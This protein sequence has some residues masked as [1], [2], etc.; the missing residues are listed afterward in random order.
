MA[1]NGRLNEILKLG[2]IYLWNG[3]GTVYA[4]V[5]HFEIGC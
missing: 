4:F 2:N 5:T 3:D 1:P